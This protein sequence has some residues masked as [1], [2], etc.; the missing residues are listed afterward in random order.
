M[1][2]HTVSPESRTF[3]EHPVLGQLGECSLS[4]HLVELQVSAQKGRIDHRVCDELGENLP[5]GGLGAQAGQPVGGGGQLG[6]QI[7]DQL[8]AGGG[9]E[10]CRVDEAGDQGAGVALS[11]LGQR[12]EVALRLLQQAG[13]EGGRWGW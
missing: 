11:E 4:G 7:V 13:R 9:G 10:E 5:C 12:V 6:V 2:I 1:L 3:F 8:G